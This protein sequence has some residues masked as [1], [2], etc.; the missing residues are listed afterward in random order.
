MWLARAILVLI[1]LEAA[2][3]FSSC[4]ETKRVSRGALKWAFKLN[5]LIS[6]GFATLTVIAKTIAG[7]SL[8][9]W[10][11]LLSLPYLVR[12]AIHHP[13]SHFVGW[14]PI[15]SFFRSRRLLIITRGESIFAPL[16]LKNWRRAE[17]AGFSRVRLQLQNGCYNAFQPDAE[18]PLP[19]LSQPTAQNCP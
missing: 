15:M 13:F 3:S 9:I 10:Y 18:E 4:S 17:G 14:Q 8:V 6:M 2:Q 7:V 11:V 16:S 19:S 12:C 1:G 5:R